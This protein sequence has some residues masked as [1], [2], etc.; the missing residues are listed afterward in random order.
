MNS[1]RALAV[2]LVVA[3]CATSPEERRERLYENTFITPLPVEPSDRPTLAVKDLIDVK[4][5][6]TTAGSQFLWKNRP[7]A[8]R[9]AACLRIARSR[10]VPIVGKVNL[11]EFALGTSGLNEFFG[12]PRSP[13][14]LRRRFVP[15]GSSSGSAVAVAAGFADVS[16]GTD[17]A[18]SIRVPAAYCGVLGLKTTFGLVP[19]DGVFPLSPDHL[20]TVGPMARDVRHLELGMEWLDPGF[21]PK[22]RAARARFPNARAVTVGRFYLRDTPREIDEAIDAALRDVGFRVVVLP[23]AFRDDWETAQGHG[24]TISMVDGLLSDQQF[25]DKPGVSAA[26]KAI[27]TAAAL[28]SPESYREALAWRRTWRRS[29]ARVFER[30]DFIALPTTNGLPPRIPFLGRTAALESLVFSQQN[31][32]AVNYAGNPAIAIPVPI[33]DDS[34]PVTSLQLIGPRLADAE[35]IR[36]AAIIEQHYENNK[37]MRRPEPSLAA[38]SR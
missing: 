19:L 22:Y 13:L 32:V 37:P 28:E 30:V 3:G 4:G 17:T 33:E 15:G 26:T 29:L 11:S 20:D 2:L 12:T 9:D 34:V 18:G 8:T 21:R 6:V 35:L 5:T 14:D 27:L 36:A 1:W 23:E 31:T 7:P 38:R 24:G 25:R 10:G 16:F